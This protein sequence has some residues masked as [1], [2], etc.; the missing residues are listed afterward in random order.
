L[1]C[2]GL[3]SL[4]PLRSELA[5]KTTSETLRKAFDMY[6]EIVEAGVV[7]DRQTK[8]S[9]GYGFVTFRD[10]GMQSAAGMHAHACSNFCNFLR[11]LLLS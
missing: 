9:R 7:M 8:K 1:C 5:W 4:A 11:L 3:A 10:A 2:D 6:G